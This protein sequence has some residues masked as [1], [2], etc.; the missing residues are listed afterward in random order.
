MEKL[1]STLSRN[2]HLYCF[3]FPTD[4]RLYLSTPIDPVFIMLPIFE[5]A[6]MK[7]ISFMFLLNHGNWKTFLI[8]EVFFISES[9][10]N[11]TKVL[12]AHMTP[13]V[14]NPPK[15]ITIGLYPQRNFYTQNP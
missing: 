1:R 2:F 7:V 13:Y 6:R 15:L 12:I 9:L 3:C 14:W 5:E 4:G 8:S 11:R 10:V